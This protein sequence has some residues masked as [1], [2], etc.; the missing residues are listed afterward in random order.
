MRI[1]FGK[2]KKSTTDYAN[3]VKMGYIIQ[4]YL[5]EKNIF[6]AMPQ[7]LMEVLID[8]GFFRFDVREGKPLRDILRELDSKNL[9]YLLPQVR[10][11]RMESNRKWFFNALKT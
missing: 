11:D 2:Q 3:V 1:L 7:D 6:N 10:V 4:K 9:L 5:E 8:A